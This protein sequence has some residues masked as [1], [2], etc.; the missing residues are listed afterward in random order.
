MFN[1]LFITKKE[2]DLALEQY[3]ED[4]IYKEGIEYIA[5]VRNYFS[6][7]Q[8]KLE[9][10]YSDSVNF[11][12]GTPTSIDIPEFLAINSDKSKEEK[13]ATRSGS[14]IQNRKI[15]TTIKKTSKIACVPD[16]NNNYENFGG[17][18]SHEEMPLGGTL[19]AIIK[20]KNQK[21]L[22]G[23][24]NWHVLLNKN[25]EL[26]DKIFRPRLHGVK[27][28]QR[29]EETFFG[30]VVFGI[31]NKNIEVGLFRIENK[32]LITKDPEVRN[33][34]MGIEKPK[35]GKKIYKRG[36]NSEKK[37]GV[38][39]S[40]NVTV[41][42]FIAK[43]YNEIFKKQIQLKK[44]SEDGDSGS[45]LFNKNR[46]VVGLLFAADDKE[47]NS[48]S[49]ANRIDYIFNNEFCQTTFIDHENNKT[50]INKLEFDS[51]Y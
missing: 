2:A 31:I 32:K 12:K 27:T 1:S 9:F 25:G 50:S 5:V 19:G 51:F 41:K 16:N 28:R 33:K 17:S 40:N 37:E 8:Y 23:I 47:Q 35:M 3:D 20:L 38:I 43:G 45:V 11:E 34:L 24:S 18:I 15:R 10:G 29:K 4:Y 13:G 30:K 14:Q 44:M 49:Y 22:F 21:G 46:N 6:M 42:A 7:Y 36:F 26:L 39:R 48:F